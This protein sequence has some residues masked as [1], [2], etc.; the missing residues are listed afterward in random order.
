MFFL[1]FSLLLLLLNALVSKFFA[2]RF[3][4]ITPFTI[5]TSTLSFVITLLFSLTS[6]LSPD[7][8][9]S[10]DKNIFAIPWTILGDSLNHPL[11]EINNI[12]LFFLIPISILSILVTIYAYK[13]FLN[14]KGMASFWCAYYLLLASMIAV[15]LSKSNLFFLICWEIMGLSSFFLVLH[16]SEKQE[17]RRAAWIYL[18]LTHFGTFAIILFFICSSTQKLAPLSPTTYSVCLFL[19]LIGF[20]SKSGI[21]PVHIW[22]PKAHALAPSPVSALMSGLMIKVGVY[23]FIRALMTM[24]SIHTIN[25]NF[26]LVVVTIGI[27]SGIGGILM[28]LA[29]HDIKRLLAYC[30][31]ENIG[32]IYIG[33]GLGL[34]GLSTNNLILATLGFAGGL[35][36]VFNHA[37][38][39]CLLFLSAGTVI[40]VTKTQK[41]DKL[42]GLLKL[43]PVTAFCFFIG[44]ISISGIPPFNGFISEF[45]IYLAFFKTTATNPSIIKIELIF[46]VAAILALAVI[47]GLA[48][49]CFAKIFS[50]V[51]LGNMRSPELALKL[52][53]QINQN[54]Q[55][56]DGG[57]LI[58]IPQLIICSLCTLIGFF[59]SVT[60][61][62]LI[63]PVKSLVLL[64]SISSI[65]VIT[66]IE[67]E[68]S[69]LQSIFSTISFTF[70]L[71]GFLLI[72]FFLLRKIK[73]KLETTKE[74]SKIPIVPTWDCGYHAPTTKMQ[75]SASS[76]A[77]TLLNFFSH[78]IH[79]KKDLSIHFN[80]Y[81]WEDAKFHSNNL[82]IITEF[83]YRSFYHKILNFLSHFTRIQNGKIHFYLLYIVIFLILMLIWC[84]LGA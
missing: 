27:I 74:K 14:K 54:N 20:G 41:M 67:Q 81:F 69:S 8:N 45:L 60:L 21:V 30:S 82:D 24:T 66:Q 62:L 44:A 13:Y 18:S 33:I 35:L 25:L 68:F 11:L 70:L 46:I 78:F 31:V 49:F 83:F 63:N 9:N 51:F 1:L 10:M 75:Y 77:A 56:L 55:S 40:S 53:H 61:P 84:L 12:A 65:S 26:A 52:G 64:S 37:L 72:S 32:I 15:V 38:F 22:L 39:K 42:G 19:A 17:T 80:K 36:H 34:I 73:I 28:T 23:G 71:F 43:M 58:I 79:T 57:K 76:F 6:L 7:M 59:P 3:Q 48:L 4:F 47:G 5:C 50:I 29:Q 16:E 2:N